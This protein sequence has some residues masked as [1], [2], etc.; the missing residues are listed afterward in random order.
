VKHQIITILLILVLLGIGSVGVYT[1]YPLFKQ[2]QQIKA[3]RQAVPA[4]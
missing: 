3:E 4:M 2:Q 1:G